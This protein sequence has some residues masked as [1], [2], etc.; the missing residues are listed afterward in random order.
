[1]N[2]IPQLSLL[3][4]SSHV[5]IHFAT[6][7]Y[8]K[9]CLCIENSIS[10]IWILKINRYYLY[11]VK[12]LTALR[13]R[14]ALYL[15]AFITLLLASVPGRGNLPWLSAGLFTRL[16]PSLLEQHDLFITRLWL[17][18]V[19]KLWLLGSYL[20]CFLLLEGKDS[21]DDNFGQGGPC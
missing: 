13:N 11:H 17:F 8:N 2:S 7:F 9:L 12:W 3:K 19:K 6:F 4:V 14:P 5:F 18:C 21:S 20:S 1:M 10:L 15:E 16:I